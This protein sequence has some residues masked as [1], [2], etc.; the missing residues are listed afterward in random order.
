MEIVSRGQMGNIREIIINGS[1]NSIKIRT[2]YNIRRILAPS[3]PNFSIILNRHNAT[4]I[5]N[6]FMLPSTFFSFDI[7]ENG[8]FIFG[9][10]FG[11]GVG[12]S[13]H[14][15]FGMSQR[16]YNYIEI[17]KHFYPNANIVRLWE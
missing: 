15:A 16:G 1:E 13:Q 12:M 3:S 10:G 2:E 14:G 5:I 7:I 11:H 8:I 17:L 9:G 4:H 6:H